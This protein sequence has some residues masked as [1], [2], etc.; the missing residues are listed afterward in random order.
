MI[1]WR[2]KLK[3]NTEQECRLLEWLNI[4]TGI[5]N[6]AI[7]KIG[8]DRGDGILYSRLDFQNILAGHSKKLGLPSCVMQG[9]LVRAWRACMDCFKKNKGVHPSKWAKPRLKGLKNPLKSLPV[10]D[11]DLIQFISR[12]R[13][14][15]P[16]LGAVK[17]CPAAIPEGKVKCGFILREPSGW[18]LC[19]VIDRPAKKIDTVPGE[20]VGIDPGFKSLL[21][22]STGESVNNPP[23]IQ[24][25][26]ERTEARIKQANR[27]RDYK[28]AARLHE[29]LRNLKKQRNHVISKDLIKRFEVI[30][31][32]KDNEAG[33]ARVRKLKN[34]S[35]QK[36]RRKALGKSVT[37]ATHYQ[38]REMIKYKALANDRDY[39]EVDGRNTT[40]RCSACQRL[41]GPVGLA[42][43][44]TRK[45]TCSGC[46][47]EHNRDTNAA[48]NILIKAL[49]TKK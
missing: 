36:V 14:K 18:Y 1:Q 13:V 6:W 45:W 16:K 32:A 22:L 40:K 34:K 17:M 26:I 41:T 21:S 2:V 37:T 38:L 12:N 47:A 39:R 5:H 46:N 28:L 20:V 27:G 44:D 33:M 43:L 24:A 3:P 23:D 31:I 4:C 42:G 7:R 35:G 9:V 29:R 48:I 10:P 49:A 30:A 8:L 25:A 11:P 19:F 15:L